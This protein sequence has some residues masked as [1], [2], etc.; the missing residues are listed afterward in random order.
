VSTDRSVAVELATQLHRGSGLLVRALG[1]ALPEATPAEALVLAVLHDRGATAV[2]ELRADL[3]LRPSTC[4]S[5]LDRLTARKSI[6]RQVRPDDR[7]S[8]LVLLTE[9]GRAEAQLVATRLGELSDA[10]GEGVG[11]DTVAALRRMGA[12]LDG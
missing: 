1:E 7:R 12:R 4:T 3:G 8:F 6:V 10:L 2:G 9:A 11:T 5:I